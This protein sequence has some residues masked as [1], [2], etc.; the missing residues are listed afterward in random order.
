MQDLL[1]R[2]IREDGATLLPAGTP[3]NNTAAEPTPPLPLAPES[4]PSFETDGFRVANALGLDASLFAAIGGS[5]AVTDILSVSMHVAFWPATVEYFLK[6]AMSPL[7][8]DIWVTRARNSFVSYVR[9]NG[10][11]P[12][13]LIG[14]QPFGILPV[15][16]SGA[17]TNATGAVDPFM[18]G[19]QKLSAGWLAAAA[20]VPRLGSSSDAG[21]DVIA[22]LSQSAV[23]RR[24]LGRTVES[25]LI[26][27]RDFTGAKIANYDTAIANFRTQKVQQ[28]LT[29]VGLSG[30]PLALDFIFNHAAFD[31]HAPLVAPDNADR[32][33]PLAANYIAAINAAKVDDLKSEN[34]AG[35]S[36]RTLLYMFLRHSTLLLLAEGAT[37][38]INKP[39][40]QDAVF[41]ESTADTV[42]TRLN[43]PVAVLGNKSLADSFQSSLPNNILALAN[44]NLHRQALKTLATTS[45]GDLERLAAG[46]IDAASH[47]L[48]AWI[49]AQATERLH[50]MRIAAPTGAHLGAYAWIDAPAVPASPPADGA[51]PFPDPDSQGFLHAPRLEH[52]RTAAI[53]RSA[54]LGRAF[55][56]A[57]AQFAIDLSSDRVRL[58]KQLTAEVQGG[59]NLSEVLSARIE[60]LMADL[61]LGPQL[62]A[63]RAQ[64]PLD[65]GDGRQRIDGVALAQSWRAAPPAAALLPVYNV[66]MS[67]ID[68]VGDLLLSEAIHKQSSGSAGR[69]RTALSAL[70]TGI[71]LPQDF[72]VVRTAPDSLTVTWRLVLPIAET[73][74][75]AWI[76]SLT[77]DPAH[78]S[79]TVAKDGAAPKTVTLTS[80]NVTPR[81]LLDFVQDGPDAPALAQKFADAAGGSGSVTFTPALESALA[82]AYAIS[83]LLRNA[84][85][86]SPADLGDVARAPL[87]GFDAASKRRQWLHDVGR[88]RQPIQAVSILDAA[89][90][91]RGAALP[92]QFASA[93][94]NLSLVTIGDWPD[95]NATGMLLDGWNESTPGLT[96]ATGVALH[97]NAPRSRP[98]QA[99]LLMV[100]PNPVTGWNLFAVESILSETADLARMRMV[101]PSDVHGSFLPAL[102][103]AD[104]LQADTVSTNF[105]QAAFITE[106]KQ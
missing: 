19:L 104:N 88:V 1:D 24:W 27:G 21:S 43:T 12:S 62:P 45:V 5:T 90:A 42:W 13:L 48:D 9:P 18:Q 66:L 53:L 50:A 36:P 4:E 76:A 100:P 25:Q 82:V 105:I 40:V 55:S 58:A 23:S 33:S 70:E 69:A 44:I 28:E 73:A 86:L 78:L 77:G 46:A 29:P 64:F 38:L 102:Y 34:L 47:R 91:A 60:R 96:A 7:F 14:S 39:A 72:D 61:G 98:P 41:V 10:P 26:S 67:T 71:T 93:G 22:I 32:K 83:L 57:Q 81:S 11:F 103:F 84:R 3:T 16:S 37:A 2:H 6:Q 63:L 59:G 97:Y 15:T 94:P 35:A 85:P 17:W 79:A 89:L 51:P 92:L 56:G 52:A 95:A 80:L 74:L 54:Y 31:I 8:A 20:N 75:D 106:V 99:I 65:S 68:A 101:R 30:S 87:T 49:T